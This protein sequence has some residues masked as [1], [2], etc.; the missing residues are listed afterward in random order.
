M[1]KLTESSVTAQ[2]ALKELDGNIK[3]WIDEAEE[4]RK[5]ASAKNENY[6]VEYSEGEKNAYANL[7]KTIKAILGKL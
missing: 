1:C 6:K 2:D 3:Q 4:R 5:A 7:S